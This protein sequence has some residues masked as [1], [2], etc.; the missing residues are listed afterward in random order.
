M[1]TSMGRLKA[2][3]DN[4]AHYLGVPLHDGDDKKPGRESLATVAVRTGVILGAAYA[5]RGLLGLDDG[6]TGFL[7]LLG[8]IVVFAVTWGLLTLAVR[9]ARRRVG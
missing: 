3:G 1:L 9:R 6:S 4:V 7:S 5:V 8:L 2:F